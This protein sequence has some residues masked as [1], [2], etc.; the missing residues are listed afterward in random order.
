MQT[1]HLITE[2]K[3]SCNNEGHDL[4]LCFS[5]NFALYGFFSVSAP[6]MQLSYVMRLLNLPLYRFNIIRKTWKGINQT[7][8][9]GGTE[10]HL[11]KI[12]D[13]SSR[14]RR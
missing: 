5:N 13:Q 7:K 6:I 11:P 2:K 10:R 1:W 14:V 3:S 9:E 8:M 4:K 12:D